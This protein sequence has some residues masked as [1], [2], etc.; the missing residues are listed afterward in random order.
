M[1]PTWWGGGP[2]VGS[3]PGL[4]Q[5]L[6]L[7]NS[8]GG[9]REG[10]VPAP[11]CGGTQGQD[12]AQ[13]PSPALGQGGRVGAAERG[14]PRPRGRDRAPAAQWPPT[15]A[16]R[17]S[18]AE[19]EVLSGGRTDLHRHRGSGGAGKGLPGNR[20]THLAATPLPGAEEPQDSIF[21]RCHLLRRF[22]SGR[23]EGTVSFPETGSPV[24][25]G[26]RGH[27]HGSLEGETLSPPLS[28]PRA[29]CALRRGAG[30]GLPVA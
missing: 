25:G 15:A 16:R 8:R 2:Q 17:L 3:S 14:S 7:Q 4:L 24:P 30:Q 21:T 23:Q 5:P 27:S 22:C 20:Q 9:L 10:A 19:L 28:G 6:I 26:D 1:F 12:A 29:V 13:A 18:P 11:P